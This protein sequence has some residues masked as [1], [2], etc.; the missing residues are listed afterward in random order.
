MDAAALFEK[1]LRALTGNPAETSAAGSVLCSRLAAVPAAS[2]ENMYR[3]LESKTGETVP[4][5]AVPS[6]SAR[7]LHSMMDP[8][9][10]AERL[11][12]ALTEEGFLIFLGLGG[13]FA[14][15]AALRREA[16][17]RILV[18][19]YGCGGI[20]ELLGARDYSGLF[21]DPRFSLLVDP[22][23]A[24]IEEFITR[25]YLPATHGGIRVFPLLPRTGG[26]TR[27]GGALEGIKHAIDACTRDYSVQA[28]F[29]KRW[30]SNILRNLGAAE[31]SRSFPAPVRRAA[32]TAAGP[33]LDSQLDRLKKERDGVFLIATDT[34]F[35]ALLG[36]GIEPDGV[37]SIDCQHTGY[38]HFFD[39]LP[40]K[41]I[42]F[43]DLASPH[44]IILRPDNYI[45]CAGDH[46][47]V[48][49]IRSE[50]LPL[51]PLDTSGANV[52]CAAFS[53]A[54]N[55]G[56]EEITL[57]GA[58]FSY[59]EGKTY[60][61]GTYVYPFFE[62][63][64]NRFLSLEAQHS[65]FLYR[66]PLEKRLTPDGNGGAGLWRYQTAPLNFYRTA[67]EQKAA[68]SGFLLRRAEDGTARIIRTGSAS[69]GGSSGG[70]KM[71]RR[72]AADFLVTYKQKLEALSS[73]DAADRESRNIVTTILPAAAAIRRQNPQP[74]AGALFSQTRAWC[75]EELERVISTCTGN[76]P[77]R[78]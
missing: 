57:Y 44:T 54:E 60:A 72:G 6:G 21:G 20:A 22:A 66:T 63:K 65:A 4:A 69:R 1:N 34:S 29:G 30:F 62:N 26:E 18:I 11:I 13:G 17:R 35:P 52:T 32:I 45:F 61:R 7:P 47:L 59:P 5:L 68:A 27:F 67:L 28:W 56:A 70:E 43:L 23:P 48:R 8:R 24:E 75:I 15:L 46:P 16:T 73:F 39:T 40:Q 58:D 25:N 36:A 19:D 76:R 9:R 33:S 51:P 10:E 37:L 12:A 49:Y 64:Q 38:R 42:L 2:G 53:L 50:W 74:D 55:L 41:T 71:P 31:Q 3:F 78:R 77:C 14:P